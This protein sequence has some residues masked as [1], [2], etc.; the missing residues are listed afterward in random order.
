MGRKQIS[1][2]AKHPRLLELKQ[3]SMPNLKFFKYMEWLEFLTHRKKTCL[4]CMDKSYPFKGIAFVL[5][6][7]NLISY[8]DSMLHLL[9]FDFQQ[10]HRKF[11]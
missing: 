4:V 9:S 1:N 7:Y 10:S 5:N 8:I 6:T 2:L 11:V 3:K